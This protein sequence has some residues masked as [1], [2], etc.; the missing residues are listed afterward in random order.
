MPVHVHFFFFA[1]MIMNQ[2][3]NLEPE[4]NVFT[5]NNPFGILV[6]KRLYV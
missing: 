6:E 2:M 5:L 1:L 4:Y 3:I